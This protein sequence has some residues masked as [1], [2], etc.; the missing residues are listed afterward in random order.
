MGDFMRSSSERLGDL[1]RNI[2]NK[3]G[4]KKTR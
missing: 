3:R 1:K 2:E 4:G